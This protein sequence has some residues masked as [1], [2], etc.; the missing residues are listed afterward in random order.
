MYHL[1]RAS[2]SPMTSSVVSIKCVRPYSIN[3]LY[4]RAEEGLN[5]GS[6]YEGALQCHLLK[7]YTKTLINIYA[8][9]ILQDTNIPQP[10]GIF[11]LLAITLLNGD[12]QLKNK[13]RKYGVDYMS[14]RRWTFRQ[15]LLK[16]SKCRP[17][18]TSHSVK[19]V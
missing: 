12:T 17:P 1:K 9:Q 8:S 7:S 11:F 15:Y 6:S 16:Y 19:G 13:Q 5:T 2:S 10:C 18:P 14:S 4:W 3:P